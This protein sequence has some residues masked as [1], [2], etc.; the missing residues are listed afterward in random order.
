M[1]EQAARQGTAI[2]V[3]PETHETLRT[4]AEREHVSLTQL[5]ERLAQEE[6]RRVRLQ[7]CNE[8][9]ARL[10]Q[11]PEAWASYQAERRDFE[12]TLGDGLHEWASDED[13]TDESWEFEDAAG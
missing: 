10:R 11:N 3:R 12:G 9:F 1:A 8:A 4:L 6:W 2:R 5:V 7:E 13:G